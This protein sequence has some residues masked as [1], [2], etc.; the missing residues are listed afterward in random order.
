[1]LFAAAAVALE[2]WT[3]GRFG[4][5]GARR[6]GAPR[7]VDP[8]RR[9]ARQAA[10]RRGRL[11]ALRGGAAAWRR[12]AARTIASGACR[13]SSPTCTAGQA[14]AETV[15]ERLPRPPRR[16][17]RP[18]LRLR[19]QL[20]R[21]RRHRLVR[22]RARPAARHLRPQQ[23]LAVGPAATATARSLLVIGGDRADHAP[24]FASVEP[25]AV[26]HCRDCMPYEDDLTIWIGRG[27][28]APVGAAWAGVKHYD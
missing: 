3:A 25:G 7:A 17:P 11:R 1:M 23:L 19:Q 22:P 14:L 21:G 12:G 5:P 27:L 4:R 18:R 10:P 28:K 6:G 20:R 2:R 26:F 8:V 13:S 15:A 9:A 16:R 24:D